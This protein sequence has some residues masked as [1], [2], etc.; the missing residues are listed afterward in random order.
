[1]IHKR[2]RRGH[3]YEDSVVGFTEGLLHCVERYESFPGARWCCSL[4]VN[5]VARTIL[6]LEALT[7]DQE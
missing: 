4:R 2:L 1:L 7:H 5:E 6:S 3:I